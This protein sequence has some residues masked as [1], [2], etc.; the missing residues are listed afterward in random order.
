M[1]QTARPILRVAERTLICAVCFLVPLWDL[2]RRLTPSIALP[3]NLVLFAGACVSAVLLVP[4]LGL[5]KNRWAWPQLLLLPLCGILSV[6]RGWTFGS[7]EVAVLIRVVTLMGALGLLGA[8]LKQEE[9]R[10]WLLGFLGCWTALYVLLAAAGIWAA[11]GR[12]FILTSSHGAALGLDLQ[13]GRLRLFNYYTT[14]GAE[15]CLSI[16]LS[17]LG[18]ALADR[19]RSKA[20]FLLAIPVFFVA[21][22]LTDSKNAI[23]CTGGGLGLAAFV[24][25]RRRFGEAWSLARCLPLAVGCAA[26]C[27]ALA[28][29]GTKGVVTA[30]NAYSMRCGAGEVT[31]INA[32]AEYGDANGTEDSAAENV[33]DADAAKND[34]GTG[35][36]ENDA[37]GSTAENVVSAGSSEIENAADCNDFAVR[38]D[39]P[40]TVRTADGGNDTEPVD[41]IDEGVGNAAV[42]RPLFT[43]PLNGRPNIWRESIHF[44]KEHP[45]VLLV[46][47]SIAHCGESFDGYYEAAAVRFRH[48]HCM[49]LQ[50]LVELGVLGLGLYLWFA[51]RLAIAGFRLLFS[52]GTALWERILPIPVACILISE[53]VESITR[54]ST[55]AP[56]SSL[57]MLLAGMV[58]AVDAARQR[59][60]A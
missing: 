28:L 14:A 55:H 9:R 37:D 32:P 49:P 29:L 2:V 44:L 43:D 23:L 15:L 42:N 24:C 31:V 11:V 36:A 19:K 21:L 3:V 20:L 47:T 48:L 34:A 60:R 51:V 54:L 40:E 46:G 10:K 16:Q 13:F 26:V 30:F 5:R 4:R 52:R 57:L 50:A 27:L 58:F 33:A 7:S 18:A 6:A 8:Y 41:M 22:A 17:C 53:L 59:T 25:L 39:D 38:A 1:K 45:A 12:Y 56:S 35:A